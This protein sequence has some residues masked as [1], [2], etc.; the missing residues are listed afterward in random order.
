M[1][2]IALTD[3]APA[4]IRAMTPPAAIGRPTA[5]MRTRDPEVNLIFRRSSTGPGERR[6]P[7]RD[8]QTALEYARHDDI[9]RIYGNLLRGSR[10]HL[11]SLVRAIE[12]LGLVYEAQVLTQEEVDEIVDSPME[13]GR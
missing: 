2:R 7:V 11:R 8:I 3:H 6:H 12:G 9:I 4:G 5:R 13:R 1:H 10:N